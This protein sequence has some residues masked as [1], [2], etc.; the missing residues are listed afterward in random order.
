M[1]TPVH[2]FRVACLAFVIL[3]GHQA[4]GQCNCTFTLDKTNYLKSATLNIIDAASFPTYKPGDVFC[5]SAGTYVEIRLSNFHGTA[6][7]PLIFKNCGGQAIIQGITYPGIQFRSSSHVRITGTGHDE[8]FYGIHI[9]KT[10]DGVAGISVQDLSTDFEIDHCEISNVGFAGIIAKTDPD[11]ARPE[12]WRENFTMRNLNFHDNYIHDTGGEGFYVGGTFGYESTKKHCDLNG[13]GV[14]VDV[15]AHLLENVKISNN[16]IENTGWDG[17]QLNLTLVNAEVSNNSIY[18]YGWKKEFAQNQGISLGSST[19]KMFNNKVI[20]KPE[21]AVPDSYGISMV[22]PFPGSYIYNNV[23]A[24]SGDYGIWTHIRTPSLLLGGY[25]LAKPE[26]GIYYINNTVVNAGASGMFYNARDGS[27]ARGDDFIHV[28][29]NNL[30]VDPTTVYTDGTFWKKSAEAFIDYNDKEQKDFADLKNNLISRDKAAIKFVDVASN[31]FGILTGSQAIDY[32]RDVS[33][34]GVTFDFNLGARP[35]GAGFDAGAFEFGA[36]NLAP[37][38]D[39]GTGSSIA[40]GQSVQLKGSASFD[41]DGTIAQYAWTQVSGPSSP[42]ISSGSSA[43]ASVTISTAGIYVFKLTV[44]DN[45]GASSFDQVEIIVGDVVTGLSN[46]PVSFKAIADVYPNPTS[47]HD[48]TMVKFN[49]KKPS[50]VYMTLYSLTGATLAHLPKVEQANSE[51]A[52]EL[53][54]KSLEGQKAVILLLRT[55]AGFAAQ[56]IIIKN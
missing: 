32:G 50:D 21:Y 27:D 39:A 51:T 2:F 20:Q 17:L 6:D 56:R 33:A 54:I 7:K 44:T 12:T 34:L 24:A 16:Q 35:V 40:V 22:S 37:V 23:V 3:F 26:N 47:S 41:P 49:L 25:D 15:F 11:C 9:A 38:A 30:I 42:T 19:V 4:N 10:K 29:Y 52:I 1:K 31:N 53:D 13:N 55:N 8:L 48:K 18:G 46:S 43:Q 14:L 36:S 45:N 5:I 28:F